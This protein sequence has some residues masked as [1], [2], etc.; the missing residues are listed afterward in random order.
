LQLAPRPLAADATAATLVML[1]NKGGAECK[2]GAVVTVDIADLQEM[3]NHMREAIDQGLADLE[4][5]QGSN[6]LP[7]LPASARGMPTPAQFAADAPPPDPTAAQ[8]IEAQ[9]QEADRAEAE[10]VSAGAVP[11][12]PATSPATI[13]LGQ[14]I[15]QVVGALGQPKSIVDLGTRKIYV[16]QDLRVTFQNG[17]VSDVQ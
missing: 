6:G 2:K 5:R 10:A 9:V 15:E 4:S 16:Y 13:S 3:Q 12:A 11:P 17:K 1:T 8:Q 14:T 7:A